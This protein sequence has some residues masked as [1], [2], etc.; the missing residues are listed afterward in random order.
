MLRLA[1]RDGQWILFK[2]GQEYWFVLTDLS[3]GCLNSQ[4]REYNAV[5]ALAHME[6]RGEA[7]WVR[8]T[9]KAC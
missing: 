4:S 5:D 3:Y 7:T 2:A 9:I 8:S 1:Q 6:E